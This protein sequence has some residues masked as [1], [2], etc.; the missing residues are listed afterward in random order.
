MPFACLVLNLTFSL[1]HSKIKISDPHNLPTIRLRL[2]TFEGN[3]P[4]SG[5]WLAN[6]SSTTSC[7]LE[8]GGDIQMVDFY[9]A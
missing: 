9:T 6:Q 7:K 8:K 4:V 3:A 1:E 2:E 5:R